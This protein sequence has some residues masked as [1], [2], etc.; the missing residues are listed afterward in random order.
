MPKDRDPRAPTSLGD[1]HVVADGGQVVFVQYIDIG[2][3]KR[4]RPGSLVKATESE[5]AIEYSPTLRLSTPHRFRDSGETFIQ[6]DQEGRAFHEDRKELPAHTGAEK[7]Q[8]QERALALLGANDVTI[9]RSSATRSHTDT[10]ATTFGRSSWIYC[11]SVLPSAD[12]RQAWRAHL[13]EKYD[14]ETIIRQP[15]KFAQALGLMFV[16]K[17][18]PQGQQGTLSHNS[19]VKSVHDTQFVIHGPVWYTDDVLGLLEE[20]MSDPRHVLYPLFVKDSRYR[21]QREYRFVVHCETAVEGPHLDLPIS[22]MMRDALAP[23]RFRSPVQFKSP[24]ESQTSGTPKVTGPTPKSKT[25]TRT[26]R[27][28]E[29][30][31]W[32]LRAGR[33]HTS[34]R[35]LKQGA[36]YHS[37]NSDRHRRQRRSDQR[38]GRW[39]A[40][41]RSFFGNRNPPSGS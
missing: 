8:E 21:A 10:E 36:G 34:G 32:T 13:P 25:T 24:S 33:R 26:K 11:T 2:E 41:R 22:G 19:S 28:T 31:R 6:D 3:D 4:D 23:V 30:H 40:S 7:T 38:G 18:G 39:I 9:G 20:R 29:N 15:T 27:T 14:H 37:D 5:Y 17:V 12:Q 1:G 16:D 35:V